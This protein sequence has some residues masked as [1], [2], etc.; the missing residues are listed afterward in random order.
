MIEINTRKLDELQA[1][2][3]ASSGEV[4]NLSKATNASI[5]NLREATALKFE[6]FEGVMVGRIQTVKVESILLLMTAVFSLFVMSNWLY[7]SKYRELEKKMGVFPRRVPMT[8]KEKGLEARVIELERM[9][10]REIEKDEVSP[11]RFK[12]ALGAL[13]RIAGLVVGACLLV[14]ALFVVLVLA[15]VL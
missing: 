9:L 2:Q 12:E 4:E 7:G 13:V 8:T 3:W 1:R 6:Q 15:G 11:S 10:E 5:M 14:V